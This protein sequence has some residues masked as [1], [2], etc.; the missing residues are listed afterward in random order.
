MH[1]R[2]AIVIALLGLLPAAA[3]H[4]G[5]SGDAVT[6]YRCTDAGG[7]VT[8]GDTPCARGSSEEVRTLQRP[9]DGQPIAA[10]PQPPP[11]PADAAQA[12]PVVVMRTP[13]PMYECVTDRGERYTSDTGDGNPRWVPAWVPAYGYGYG[14]PYTSVPAADR[15]AVGR[16]PPLGGNVGAP[17]PERPP[18]QSRP[19]GKP[20]HPPHR[21]PS[22]GVVAAG[23]TW[24]RDSCHALP[25]AE[26]CS[27]VHD[28]REELR[29]R[30]FNAQESERNRL[31]SEERAINARLSADCGIG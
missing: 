11:A 4:A 23:G 17:P 14:R 26:V 12:P 5:Q 25:P 16:P 2:P 6:V 29:R 3:P 22:H 28:R 1:V 13:Q 30:F 8:L 20:P 9:V 10:A 19:G 15:R 27:R 31:R 24:V 21:H 18:I 7:H